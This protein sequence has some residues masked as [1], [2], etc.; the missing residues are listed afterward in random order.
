ME[1]DESRQSD[2][3]RANLAGI[4]RRIEEAAKSAGRESDKIEIVAV[5][6]THP[7][8]TLRAAQEAGLTLFGENYVQEALAK[9]DELRDVPGIVWHFIGH[10]QSNKAQQVVGRFALIQ[11]IDSDKLA[12]KVSQAAERLGTTQEILIQVHLGDEATKFGV[13]PSDLMALC[14]KVVGFSNLSLRG[15]MGIAPVTAEDGSVADPRP[16]FARLRELVGALPAANRQV[17]S[18]GMSGDFEAA[19][20]E[21]ATMVRIGTALLGSRP[22]KPAL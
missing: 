14:E 19:V 2:V 7:A 5:T 9:Q 17:L 15:L 21:G 10:L 20:Q 6:K 18:M 11:T 8:G 4:K 22:G 13:M 12:S 1:T 16:Y 3:I